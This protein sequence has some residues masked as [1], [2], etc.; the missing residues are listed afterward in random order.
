M[1]QECCKTKMVSKA[2]ISEI[3]LGEKESLSTSET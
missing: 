2:Y 3:S 1:S